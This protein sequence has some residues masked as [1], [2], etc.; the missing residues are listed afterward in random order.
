MNVGAF[1]LGYT[2]DLPGTMFGRIGIGGDTTMYYVPHELQE[3]YGAPLSFHVFLRYRFALPHKSHHIITKRA[4]RPETRCAD[5]PRESSV[6]Q[7]SV[8]RVPVN[9][10]WSQ[11]CGQQCL[12]TS[13]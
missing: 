9:S 8:D 2:R 13:D 7:S 10:Q 1:T 3:S 12:Q 11:S 4:A 6:S 5:L